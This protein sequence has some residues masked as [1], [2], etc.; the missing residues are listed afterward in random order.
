[1]S[2]L[3]TRR[4]VMTEAL[5][6]VLAAGVLAAAAGA[7]EPGDQHAAAMAPMSDP[8][9]GAFKDGAYVLPPLPYPYDALEPY[10]DAETMHLH[11]DK[12]HKAYV[13][14]LNKTLKS[15]AELRAA[16]SEMNTAELT[17]LEEDLSF[18]AAGHLLHTV[19]W[20]VM[21]PKA[22]GEPTGMIGDAIAKAFGSA[23]AFKAQFSKAAASVK[24]SGWAVLAYEPVGDQLFILQL[25]QHDMQLPPGIITLLPLDVW[26]HAYY[27]KYRNAR[28]EYIKAWWNVV[29]W[30]RVHE[31]YMSAKRR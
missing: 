29:S 14:G 1:M 26:E 22:G 11:H 19:F 5:P 23:A 31:T 8:L 2:E 30:D 18:N 24:G 7:A 13:D 25:K 3:M 12:H 21:A 17:A 4:G 10:I 15:L 27:L 20:S 9:A 6:S 28:A 16:G